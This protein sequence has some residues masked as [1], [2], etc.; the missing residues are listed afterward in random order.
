MDRRP[1]S[2]NCGKGDHSI[3]DL[4]TIELMISQYLMKGRRAKADAKL[5]ALRT[6]GP[7]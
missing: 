6:R 4:L 7:K 2:S 3:T 1:D 5:C